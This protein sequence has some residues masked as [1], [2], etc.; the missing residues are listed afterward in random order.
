VAAGGARAAA[1]GG[2][3]GRF[4]NGQSVQSF[5]HLVEAFRRGL[6]EVSYVDGQN[7]AIEFR[8]ADGDFSRL[9][10]LADELLRRPVAVLVATGGAQS[11][12]KDGPF[13]N[14]DGLHHRS[15]GG[16]RPT[17]IAITTGLSTL[18]T[19]SSAVSVTKLTHICGS[20]SILFPRDLDP[21]ADLLL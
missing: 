20:D 11:G 12:S 1:V 4:L 13:N 10:P 9:R 3:G 7:V 16:R 19:I 5:T 21:S 2:A 8:W 18:S 15:S 14:T 6:S 17:R